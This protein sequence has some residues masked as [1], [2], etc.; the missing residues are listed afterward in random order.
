MFSKGHR[1]S[2]YWGE[3]ETYCRVTEGQ[4]LL[5]YWNK[6]IQ[7]YERLEERKMSLENTLY[8]LSPY[9]FTDRSVIEIQSSLAQV[10]TRSKQRFQGSVHQRPFDSRQ[11]FL[12]VLLFPASSFFRFI[13]LFF[14]V[15]VF[16]YVCLV[17]LLG[18]FVCY[19]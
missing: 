17:H 11:K 3:G 2:Y 1:G 18:Q 4:Q 13:F 14:F 6:H 8:S 9:S 16:L 12:F 5:P 19:C 10:S 15:L 7:S